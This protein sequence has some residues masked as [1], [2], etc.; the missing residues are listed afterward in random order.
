[1]VQLV[2]AGNK[3]TVLALDS[4]LLGAASMVAPTIGSGLFEVI[5][6]P[7]VGVV[8]ASMSLAMVCLVHLR[9]LHC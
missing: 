8:G 5:G 6:F 1:M 9:V 2:P 7:A 3:G 4:S